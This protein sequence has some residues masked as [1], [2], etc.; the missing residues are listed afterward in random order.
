MN[1]KDPCILEPFMHLKDNLRNQSSDYL[2]RGSQT[3]SR[4]ILRTMKDKSSEGIFQKVSLKSPRRSPIVDPFLA[5]YKYL[6]YCKDCNMH[7]DNK[8]KRILQNPPKKQKKPKT[9]NQTN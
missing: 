7:A 6:L 5:V 8:K 1:L 9:K 2:A 3:Y 4:S